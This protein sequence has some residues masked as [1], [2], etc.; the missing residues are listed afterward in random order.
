MNMINFYIEEDIVSGYNA[1]TINH[2][3]FTQGDTIDE[4]KDNIKDAINCHFDTGKSPQ[5][6]RLHFVRQE[7]M[8]IA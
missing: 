7:L 5:I 3:I 1:R 4:L 8:E 2:G 6:V